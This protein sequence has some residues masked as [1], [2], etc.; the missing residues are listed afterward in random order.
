MHIGIHQGNKIRYDSYS[1][2][3]KLPSLKNACSPV[4][5]KYPFTTEETL[6]VTFPTFYSQFSKSVNNLQTLPI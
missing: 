2:I 5:V 3:G 4:D 1:P 6:S